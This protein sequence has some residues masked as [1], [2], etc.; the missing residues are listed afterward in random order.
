MDKTVEA[1]SKNNKCSYIRHPTGVIGQQPASSVN[2]VNTSASMCLLS[3]LRS[4][5]SFRRS[6]CSPGQVVCSFSGHPVLNDANLDCFCS[7]TG[8][9]RPPSPFIWLTFRTVILSGEGEILVRT[10]NFSLPHAF[11]ISSA[12]LFPSACFAYPVPQLIPYYYST[13]ASLDHWPFRLRS[14]YP[15]P[16]LLAP[17]YSI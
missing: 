8:I 9:R 3:I 16:L 1:K 15:G 6:G 17:T 10:P 2:L 13:S 11:L 14:Y 5:R 7:I 4:A 12:F